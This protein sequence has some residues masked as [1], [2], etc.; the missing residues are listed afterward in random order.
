MSSLTFSPLHILCAPLG[1]ENCLP[2]LRGQMTLQNH[3]T[4]ALDEYDEIYAAY[5]QRPTSYPYRQQDVYAR[6]LSE[7]EVDAAI[8]ENRWLRAE[9]LP[10]F[11]GRLWR[12]LDKRS[13]RDL[14]YTND[15]L[16]PSNLALRNA[17]FSGGVE[18]NCGV[19]GHCP[20]TMDRVFAARLDTPEGPVLRMYAYERVRGVVYQ[21]D[22]WLD[23][24]RPA[25]NA[26]FAVT[27]PEQELTPMY[28]WT[29]IA[30]PVYPGGRLLTPAHQA[31]TCQK[32]RVS[33]VDIPFPSP[34]VDVEHYE[35]IPSSRDFFFTLDEGAPRWIANVDANGTGLLHTSSPRLQSR[36]LFVWGQCEGAQ[37]WQEFLTQQAGPYLELQA[38]LGK[39]QYGCIPMAPNTTW[40]WSECFSPLQLS[41]EEMALDFHAASAAVSRRV[42][43]ENAIAPIEARGH[44]IL[45]QRAKVIYPGT[46]DACLQ[47]ELRKA[48]GLPPLRA[49]LDWSSADQRQDAFRTLLRTGVLPEPAENSFPAWDPIG[50]SWLEKLRASVRCREGDHWYTWYCIALL[51]WDLGRKDLAEEAIHHSLDRDITAVN[52]YLYA[53]LKAEKQ[54]FETVGES[55]HAGLARAGGHFSY[56]R[57]SLELLILCEDWTGILEEISRLPHQVQTSGRI[58]FDAVLALNALGRNQEA[59]D[60]LIQ[61]GGLV[62]EDVR[63]GEIST[64]SLWT[65][66]TTALY[67][68]AK[69]VPY[70]FNFDAIDP[71]EFS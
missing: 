2:D 17:W 50:S 59:M 8:L 39:T 71:E 1:A 58:R 56:A 65:R 51:E 70:R 11:G 9:F 44:Q 61:D 36:K 55:I 24:E 38:G 14:L 33:K 49:H 62:L 22:F 35:S 46:G 66:I 31:Y 16:R 15:C 30:S 29:N 32:A 42:A 7:Q 27:N 4:F 5:G 63:E 18:W 12:L 60:L 48:Q 3:L 19:I 54:Q 43:A 25:L 67:G 26:H 52:L 45:R 47:D 21:M 41:D 13:G 37:R 53:A 57:E 10:G 20:Y 6:L 23:E 64:G 28:W 68:E 69:P 40:E 34:G